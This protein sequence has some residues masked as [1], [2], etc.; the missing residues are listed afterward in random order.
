M[1]KFENVSKTFGK[2]ITALANVNLSIADGEFLF[3][4]GPSGAGKTTL[5]NLITRLSLPTS[6]SIFF[7]D[8]EVTDLPKKLIPMLRRKIGCIFQDYK[9]LMDRTVEENIALTLEVQGKAEDLIKKHVAEALDV[10]GLNGK[11]RLFPRE[12]AGGEVQR[13]AIAR[14]IIANPE[15]LLADEPTADLD[16]DNAWAIMRLLE[17]INNENKTTIIMATHNT[18]IVNRMKRRVVVM[19][20]G[21]VTNDEANSTYTQAKNARKVKVQTESMHTVEEEDKESSS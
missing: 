11:G 15:V 20:N 9:L 2:N 17:T 13:V 12:L 16:P 6:G 8:W 4:V 19:E 21:T 5:L 18:D 1:L 3:I 7:N 10:V 14:A